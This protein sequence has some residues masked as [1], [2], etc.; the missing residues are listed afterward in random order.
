MKIKPL[1]RE[2]LEKISIITPI[3]NE[4]LNLPVFFSH[5]EKSGADE[6]VLVDGGSSDQSLKRLELW[7]DKTEVI[8]RSR[9]VVSSERGRG[10]QMNEGAL[11]ADGEIFI[12]LHADSTLPE[13]AIPLLPSVMKNPEIVGGAFRLEINSTH[14]FLKWITWIANLRSKYW[15]LPY[16]DQA[17]FVRKDVFERMGGYRSMALM[18]DV[19][20]FRRLKKEGKTILLKET[21]RTSARRWQQKGFYLNSL[22]NALFLCLYFIGVSPRRLGHWYYSSR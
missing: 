17:Y 16:G 20:F 13:E 3:Y 1:S 14:W 21:V 5:L 10:R 15:K 8:P 12:F 7:A 2:R 18:E 6:V 4:A 19:D 9:I 11:R 22:R